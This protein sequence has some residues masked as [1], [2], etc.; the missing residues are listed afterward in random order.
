MYTELLAGLAG[1]VD[2]GVGSIL[3]IGVD[4]EDARRNQPPIPAEAMHH[5]S[6]AGVVNLEIDE[7]EVSS[8][9]NRRANETDD[10]RMPWLNNGAVGCDAHEPGKHAVEAHTDIVLAQKDFGEKCGTKAARRSGEGSGDSDFARDCGEAFGNLECG[11]AVETVPSEP[12]NEDAERLEDFVAGVEFD[13]LAIYEAACARAN[14]NGAHE[15]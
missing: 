4:A 10:H 8:K 13:A 11:A 3:H 6:V 12:E 14:D 1:L 2:V 15:P 5:R 7:Q 9:Q